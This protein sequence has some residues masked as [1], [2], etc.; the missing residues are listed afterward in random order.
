MLLVTL[1]A[2]A[3]ASACSSPREHAHA[4]PAAA[5]RSKATGA[6]RKRTRVGRY[7]PNANTVVLG[8]PDRDR[9]IA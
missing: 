8:A 9:S 5:A 6:R 2:A 3:P 7:M 1:L 4:D